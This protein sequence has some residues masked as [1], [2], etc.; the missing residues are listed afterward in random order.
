[1]IIIH[2][3]GMRFAAMARSLLAN[4][5]TAVIPAERPGLRPGSESRNPVITPTLP[6]PASG[7]GRGRGRTTF[8][9]ARPVI[10]GPPLARG[11]QSQ[12]LIKRVP[13]DRFAPELMDH[14]CLTA[15][16]SGSFC[17]ARSWPGWATA[18]QRGKYPL[19]TNHLI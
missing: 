12:E 18:G 2:P 13:Y 8:Q 6:S 11:R 10:T 19:F 15:P 14:R 17:R 1:M 7:G 3:A 9:I 5:P 4:I 16:V